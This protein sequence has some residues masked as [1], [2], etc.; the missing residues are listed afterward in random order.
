MKYADNIHPITLNHTVVAENY[1]DM[2]KHLEAWQL[3]WQ[4]E[5][6]YEAKSCVSKKIFNMYVDFCGRNMTF[7]YLGDGNFYGIHS[8]EIPTPVFRF[9]K[10]PSEPRIIHQ[11][12]GDTHNYEEHE[13]LYMV[14]DP[15]DIWDTVKINGKS[16]EEVIQNSCIDIY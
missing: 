11:I 9:K 5:H 12:D 3:G 6:K 4:F 7:Y 8:E 14:D 10:D 15:K 1:F 2:G 16:L 13:V